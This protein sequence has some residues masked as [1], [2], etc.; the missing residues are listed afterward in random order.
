MNRVVIVGL[1]VTL[2][3]PFPSVGESE[4][5]RNFTKK[6]REEHQKLRLKGSLVNRPPIIQPTH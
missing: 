4:L 3:G 1:D 6:N 5:A 2:K